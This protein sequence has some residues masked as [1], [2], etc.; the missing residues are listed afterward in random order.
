M[1]AASVELRGLHRFRLGAVVGMLG[2]LVGL[3]LPI[4][5]NL[6]AVYRAVGVPSANATLVH[7]TSALVIGGTVLIALS[8]LVYRNGFAA[9]RKADPRFY[10]ASVLCII[11]SVGL[12]LLGIGAA[13]ALESSPSLAQCLRTTPNLAL[14]C[15]QAAPPLTAY[16]VVVGFWMAWLGGLG[17]VVGLAMGGRRFRVIR[18]GAGSVA[19][20]VLLLVLIDP[21]VAVLF[22]INGWQYPLLTLPVLALVAPLLVYLGCHRLLGDES[23][24]ASAPVTAA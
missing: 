18:I 19:Y 10:T 13:V 9:L 21:F 22:P 1:V 7:F 5:V 12:L 15:L 11:G 4:S 23:L 3:V 6:L 14:T 20:A 17:I 16:S 2:G 8:L 24:P